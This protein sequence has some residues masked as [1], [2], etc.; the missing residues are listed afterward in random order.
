MLTQTH[1]NSICLWGGKD[2]WISS[3]DLHVQGQSWS[4]HVGATIQAWHGMVCMYTLTTDYFLEMDSRYLKICRQQVAHPL[5][6]AQIL[7]LGSRPYIFWWRWKLWQKTEEHTVHQHLWRGVY[8][9]LESC[10]A[11]YCYYC[12]V[13]NFREAQFSQIFE[14]YHFVDLSFVDVH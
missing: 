6:I 12:M 4:M 3:L 9:N 14:L 8:I 1:G 13:G 10:D 5:Q 7:M 2:G 11:Y